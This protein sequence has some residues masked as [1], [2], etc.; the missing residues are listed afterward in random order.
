MT[1]YSKA[2]IS[3]SIIDV[4]PKC[5]FILYF[6]INHGISDV[7]MCKVVDKGQLRFLLMLQHSGA[8]E[9]RAKTIYEQIYFCETHDSFEISALFS[10]A[11]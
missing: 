9:P 3:W 1:I 6:N 4:K 11:V 7:S 10:L 2:I 8:H 5:T